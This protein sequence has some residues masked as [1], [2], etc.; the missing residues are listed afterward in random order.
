MAGRR[1]PET[2]QSQ[3]VSES[4]LR[5]QIKTGMGLGGTARDSQRK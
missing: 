2:E 3:S 5:A 1:T 4:L